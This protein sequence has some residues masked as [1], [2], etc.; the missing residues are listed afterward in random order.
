MT[1]DKAVGDEAKPRAYLIMKIRNAMPSRTI[2]PEEEHSLMDLGLLPSSSLVLV[3][4]QGGG[5]RRSSG[6]RRLL[7]TTVGTATGAIGTVAGVTGGL[8]GTTVGAAA[9][10]VG[11]AAG[12]VGEVTGAVTGLVFGSGGSKRKEMTTEGQAQAEDGSDDAQEQTVSHS[13][14]WSIAMRLKLAVWQTLVPSKM[15]DYPNDKKR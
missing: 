6:R 14:R 9:G 8:I 12:T 3:P 10:V 1:E 13:G 5:Q 2:E 15:N 4:V 7:G 11:L